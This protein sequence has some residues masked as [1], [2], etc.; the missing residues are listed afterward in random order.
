MESM[1]QESTFLFITDALRKV[2]QNV[3][4]SLEQQTTFN[5][6]A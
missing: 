3:F 4:K 5:T 2:K 6:I 1:K